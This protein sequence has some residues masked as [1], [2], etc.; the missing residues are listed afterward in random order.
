MA[1]TEQ[2]LSLDEFLKLPEEKPALEYEDGVVTQ[3]VSPQGQHSLLQTT[4]AER[5][6]Q[7]GRSRKLALA[8]TELRAT[9]HGASRVPDV[10][11]YRWERI[12]RQPDGKVANRFLE[13]PDLAIEIAS[14]EQSVNGLVRR[15][16]RLVQDGVGLALLVDPGDESVLR[17]SSAATVQAL[18]GTDR[19]DLGDL[20]PG[21][22]LTVQ[23]LFESLRLA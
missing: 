12:P 21:F 15:C 9:F 22:E 4:L 1:I 6:N 5:I 8:L 13:P 17:F 19:I 16:L 20:L 3:K 10:A 11:V 14:P 23:E 7:F 18:H 2:R